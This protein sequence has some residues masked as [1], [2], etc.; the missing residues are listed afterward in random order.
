MQ[1]LSG[2]YTLF[3]S[4]SSITCLHCSP[5][6]VSGW[7]SP[8]N[9]MGPNMNG[10]PALSLSASWKSKGL[11]RSSSLLGG[12]PF[13]LSSSFFSS[14]AASFFPPLLGFFLAAAAIAACLLSSSFW[15]TFYLASLINSDCSFSSASDRRYKSQKAAGRSPFSNLSVANTWLNCS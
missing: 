12:G 10:R 1:R 2:R 7:S 4:C 9:S 6:N 15:I 14:S 13:G 5:W 3:C 11:F 8:W